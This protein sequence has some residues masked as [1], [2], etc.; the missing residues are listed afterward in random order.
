MIDRTA[1][2]ELLLDLEVRHDDLLMRLAKLDKRVEKTLA[3]CLVLRPPAESSND[4]SKPLP[5]ICDGANA[6]D[7]LGMVA[8]PLDRQPDA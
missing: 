1:Q 4:Q 3:E 5:A 2:H 6:L 7:P 8:I